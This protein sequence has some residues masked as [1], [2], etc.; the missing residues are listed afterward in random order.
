MTTGWGIAGTGG[1]AS[2]T[3]E[4]L[5]RV[6][7]AQL[8]A[9]A[10][11]SRDRARAFA[12]DQPVRA[13]SFDELISDPEVDV[14]YVATPH[15]EHCRQTLQALQAGKHVLVEKPAALSFAQTEAMVRAAS[16]SGRFLLEGMWTRHLPSYQA[17]REL[18]ADGVLGDLIQVHAEQGSAWPFVPE[19][20][21]YRRDLGGGAL[22]DLGVYPLQ[23]ALMLLGDPVEVTAH[24]ELGPTDVDHDTRA[25]LAFAGGRHATVRCSF[26]Q[27]LPGTARVIGTQ[28]WLQLEGPL[29]APESLTY[30]RG[31]GSPVHVSTPSCGEGLR[32][33]AEEVQRCLALGALQSPLM[34]WADSLLLART[35]D[36]VR[37]AIGLTFP[38]EAVPD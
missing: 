20:R 8:V 36:R 21:I 5:S 27:A 31:S 26:R 14:V 34:T 30:Q 35:V 7:G 22:L 37:T 24:A 9:V 18:V 38:D 1:I 17:L 6:E 16:D 3:A 33:Q 29:Y 23:L 12:G 10:S 15:S 2:R 4:A 11:R 19:H 28:G 32:L 25:S 13:C